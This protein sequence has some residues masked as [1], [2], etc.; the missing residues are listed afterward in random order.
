MEL[1]REG[2][3]EIDALLARIYGETSQRMAFLARHQ[4]VAHLIKLVEDERAV[5]LESGA[6]YRPV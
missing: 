6:G 3:N 4:V 1:L 5:P 2:F